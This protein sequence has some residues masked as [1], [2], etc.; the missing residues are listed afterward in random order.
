[1]PWDCVQ[2]MHI[3]CKSTYCSCFF[4]CDRQD[5]LEANDPCRGWYN[6]TTLEALA[7]AARPPTPGGG[8]QLDTRL[9]SLASDFVFKYLSR[10]SRKK[11]S[12]HVIQPPVDRLIEAGTRSITRTLVG[13]KTTTLN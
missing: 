10:N 7:P 12:P 4:S 11:S 13:F 8:V 3:V 6:E 1:M 2:H 5:N 9:L